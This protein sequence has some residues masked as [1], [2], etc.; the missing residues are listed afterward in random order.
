MI[1]IA[2]PR[3]PNATAG[4][5]SC[6]GQETRFAP[7]ERGSEA[8]GSTEGPGPPDGGFVGELDGLRVG[9]GELVA[10]FVGVSVAVRVTVGDGVLV[11]G[12]TAVGVLVGVA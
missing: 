12:G 11:A 4:G 5:S 1:V 3:S 10:V 7:G 6:A 8:C 9:V 2:S